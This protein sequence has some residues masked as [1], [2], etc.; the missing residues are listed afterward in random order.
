MACR[1]R[2]HGDHRR[3]QGAHRRPGEAPQGAHRLA[4]GGPR[5][6]RAQSSRYRHGPGLRRGGRR[7]GSRLE[8]LGAVR[9]PLPGDGVG[10][11]G[12]AVGPAPAGRAGPSC[13]SCCSHSSTR[14]RTRTPAGSCTG[15]SSRATCCCAP[16]RTCGPGSSSPTSGWRTRWRSPDSRGSAA[17]RA[18]HGARAVPRRLAPVRSLDR[19]VRA[20]LHGLGVGLRR[21]ALRRRQHRAHAGAPQRG[22]ADARAPHARA[23][24]ARR[25]AALLAAEADLE[26]VP[27]RRRCRLGASPARAARRLRRRSSQGV[28]DRPRHHSPHA[29]HDAHHRPDDG[30]G[31]GGADRQG[32]HAD[33]R[34]RAHA[35]RR[36]RLPAAP[37]PRGLAASR[38]AEPLHAP[39]RCGTRPVRPARR[40]AGG[41][42]RR[43]RRALGGGPRGGPIRPRPRCGAHRSRGCRQESPGRV[44]LPQGARGRRGQRARR[45][46][47]AHGRACRRSGPHARSLPACCGPVGR[48]AAATGPPDPA[49]AQ[50]ARRRH[51][52]RPVRAVRGAGRPGPDRALRKPARAVDAGA[53]AARARVPASAR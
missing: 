45:D 1:A 4:P 20:R 42:R 30:L 17:R 24:R 49:R 35:P 48:G 13:G 11:W 52:R 29:A 50:P 31:D 3:R 39:R 23:R 7:G 22:A 46:P 15:T 25:L 6:G 5:G 27:A 16:I 43:A 2:H 32:P 47:R 12:R 44:D 33:L 36:P 10:Q 14:S 8:G 9:K 53:T 26:P 19:H 21:A 34:R 40:A 28:R 37:D 41:P 51:P 38:R 18:L